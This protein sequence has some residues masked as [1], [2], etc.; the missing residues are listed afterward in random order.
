[1][2]TEGVVVANGNSAAVSATVVGQVQRCMAKTRAPGSYGVFL[3]RSFPVV[4]AEI[5]GTSVGVHNVNDCLQDLYNVQYSVAGLDVGSTAPVQSTQ[6]DVAA[7][8][9]P[10]RA[11]VMHGGSRYCR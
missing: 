1:M 8:G 5:G 3:D 9:C 2:A 11:D 4:Q 6:K 10:R 7:A